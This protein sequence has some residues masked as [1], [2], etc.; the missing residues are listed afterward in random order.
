MF[1]TFFQTQPISFQPVVE[2]LH[3]VLLL[4]LAVVADQ[5]VNFCWCATGNVRLLQ[6]KL[7][8]LL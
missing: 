1:L 3:D 8:L 2:L 6:T 4:L 7:D 5:L